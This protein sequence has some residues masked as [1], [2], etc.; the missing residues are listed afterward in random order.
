MGTGRLYYSPNDIVMIGL[1]GLAL[2][3]QPAAPCRVVRSELTAGCDR[4]TDPLAGPVGVLA[5][6]ALPLN[7]HFLPCPLRPLP[8]F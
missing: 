5:P 2:S 4:L 1:V 3:S 8:R 6:L 7:G